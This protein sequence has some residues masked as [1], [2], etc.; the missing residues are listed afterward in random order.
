MSQAKLYTAMDKGEDA[1]FAIC[2]MC[3]FLAPYAQTTV[4]SEV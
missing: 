1:V 2:V 3:P 4:F